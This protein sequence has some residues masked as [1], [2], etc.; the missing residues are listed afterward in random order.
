MLKHDWSLILASVCIAQ[1][2]QDHALVTVLSLDG[3]VIAEAEQ[4][5][6]ASK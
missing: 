6:Y 5:R 2:P 1:T 4:A 3:Q